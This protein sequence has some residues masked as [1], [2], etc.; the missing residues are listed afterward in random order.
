MLKRGNFFL[1]LG[2][3]FLVM[4]IP[5]LLTGSWLSAAWSATL[6]AGNLF[7]AY[8]TRHPEINQRRWALPLAVGW[9]IVLAVLT[10]MRIAAR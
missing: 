6:G 1:L 10:I 3:F 8:G 4:G 7:I 2:V 9:S 5:L